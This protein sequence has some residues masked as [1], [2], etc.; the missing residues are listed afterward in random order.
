MSSKLFLASETSDWDDNAAYYTALMK[1]GPMTMP[2]RAMLEHMNKVLPFE[3]ASGIADVGCGPGTA[4]GELF[5]IYGKQISPSA[6]LLASDFSKGMVEQVDK[7]KA[8][9]AGDNLWDRLET[10]VWDLNDLNHVSDSSFS[11]VM[12]SM[13]FFMLK[14][15]NEALKGVNRVLKEGG[16]IAATSWNKVEWMELAF[17]ASG[18]TRPDLAAKRETPSLPGGWTNPEEVKTTLEAAGFKDVHASYVKTS[19]HFDDPSAFLRWLINSK[20]PAVAELV[21]DF[22]E[23]DKTRLGD[24]FVKLVE[25]KC[26]NGPKRLEGIAVEVVGRK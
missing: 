12:G 2:I 7:R 5:D 19:C 14:D 8:N 25:Q 3:S 16:I 10:D 4:I 26:G 22:D 17:A 20:L 6:R 15:S 11:H 13:V 9:N 18:A 23:D 21:R 1:D 24:E